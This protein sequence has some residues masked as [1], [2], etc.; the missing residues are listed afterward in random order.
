MNYKKAIRRYHPLI[1]EDAGDL[2]HIMQPERQGVY[3]RERSPRSPKENY[4]APFIRLPNGYDVSLTGQSIDVH[5]T[6]D[7]LHRTLKKRVY[8]G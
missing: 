1:H 2:F 3:P 5:G 6:D 4:I 8:T 7:G